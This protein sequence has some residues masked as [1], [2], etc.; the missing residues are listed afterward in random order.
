MMSEIRAVI[1]GWGYSGRTIHASL[2]FQT[3]GIV[4]YGIVSS[5][6]DLSSDTISLV[7]QKQTEVN[8]STLLNLKIFST[9]ELACQD[10]NA[11]LIIICNTTEAHSSCAI[12]SLKARK[13][14]VVDKPMCLK[15][16]EAA[17]MIQ[18]AKENSKILTVFHNRRFDGDFKTVQHLIKEDK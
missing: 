11:D 3:P 13:H 7:S 10:P 1:V 9:L 17:E 16:S 18:I 4:L 2:I 6:K 14:V 15:V 5:Q 12:Q 8:K